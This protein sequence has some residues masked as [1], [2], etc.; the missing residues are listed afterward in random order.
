MCQCIYTSINSDVIYLIHKQTESNLKI[1]QT[2]IPTKSK[3]IYQ[4]PMVCTFHLFFK[5][6]I[7]FFSSVDLTQALGITL[8]IYTLVSF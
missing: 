2:E 1:F 3:I 5:I 6:I 8:S 7:R 4:E